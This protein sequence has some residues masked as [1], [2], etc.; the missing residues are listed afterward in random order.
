MSS[1]KQKRKL[2]SEARRKRREKGMDQ[3]S[4]E[5]ILASGL[6]DG[7]ILPVDPGKVKTASVMGE[8]PD[9]YRDKPFICRDCQSDEVW[10]AKQQKRWYEEQGGEIETTAIRCRD[11]RRKERERKHEAREVHLEGLAKKN[12]TPTRSFRS[13]WLPPEE[14]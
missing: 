6:E 9:Y 5:E 11:C 13:Q 7:S 10:T 2:L 12:K 14:P 1:N 8:I 4:E 3:R